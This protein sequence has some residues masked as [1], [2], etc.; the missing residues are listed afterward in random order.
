[1]K[2][3]TGQELR[4]AY[5]EF[6]KARGHAELGSAPL[7]PEHDPTV[8]FTTAGM[9]PL[10]PFLAGQPHPQ[11]RRLTSVQKCLRTDDIDEVGDTTHLTFFEMLGNWSLGD[12]FKKEAITWSYEFLTQV[13]GIPAERL[14]VS[15]FAGDADAPRDEESAAIWESLGIPRE[16]IYFF[17]KKQ[18]WWGPAGQTGPCGPDTEMFYFTG[19]PCGEGRGEDCDPSCDCGRYVEVWNDVFMQYNKTA[20]GTYEPLAQRNVDTGMGLE[21]TVAVLHGYDD[22]FRTELFASI[23]ERLQALSGRAYEG[24][25]LRAMRIVADHIRASTFLMADGVLPSNVEQGYILRRLLRRAMRYARMLGIEGSVLPDLAMV[26]VQHYALAYPELAEKRELIAHEIALE[27]GRFLQALQRGEREF[28]RL[29]ARLQEGQ[30]SGRD[31]FYLYETYGFPLELTAEMARERGIAVD[32]A[33]FQE[34]YARHQQMSRAGAEL[35]FAGGLADHS[36]ATTRLHT[37]THLLHAALRLVLGEHVRQA[38]SNITVDRLRFDFAHPEKLTD[39]QLQR[40]EDLVNEAIAADYPVCVDQMSLEE[41]QA[42]GALAF[43]GERYGDR[44]N[45]YSIG[46]FSKEVCGGPHVEHTGQLGHFKIQKQEAVGRGLRR[47]R[48]VLEA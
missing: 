3:L 46:E 30:I 11:G 47:I 21:R 17:G 42:S 8:L 27:E 10:V 43:F 19:E 24:E 16:R 45:V 4:R 36:E 44:V 12:Y 35:K 1:M 15:C 37:A 26:V 40:V 41:A 20:A 48:A 29:V 33:G 39:E 7:I 34:A 2:Q 38:G 22:V 13:L 9:H 6:F 5:I 28:E 25:S 23:M 31:A 14:H 18:N 32:E